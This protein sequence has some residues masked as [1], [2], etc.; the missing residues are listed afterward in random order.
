MNLYLILEMAVAQDPHRVAVTDVDGTSLTT[1]RLNDLAESASKLFRASGAT[2]VGFCGV[3]SC[4]LPVALFGS[5]LAALPFVPLNYRLA[6]EQLREVASRHDIVI[7]AAPKEA[8]R[9]HSLGLTRTIDPSE[10]LEP[11][12]STLTIPDYPPAEAENHALLLYTSGTTSAPKA[13]VL[14]HRHLTS[15]ILGS[16]EFASMAPDDAVIVCVPPYHVA[17]VMNL[18]SNLYSGRRIV[19]LD[20]FDASRWLATVHEQRVTQAMVVPTMLAR[21]VQAYEEAPVDLPSLRSISYGGALMPLKIITRALELFPNVAFT[22]AYGLTETSSTVALLGPQ[23]HRTAIASDDPTVRNR[24]RSVGHPIP[25]IA[26]EIHDEAGVALEPGVVGEIVVRGEQVAGEYLGTST[27]G[28]GWFHTRDR[29]WLDDAGYLFVEGRA[30]DTIIRGGENIAPAEI[31]DVL[32]RH[33]AV[34][35]CAVVGIDDEVWGQRIAA[36]VVLAP[37]ANV[38]PEELIA[39]AKVHL[40]TSKTPEFIAVE[41]SLPYT[42][43]G[44]L[45]RRAVREQLSKEFPVAFE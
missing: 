18:L 22:N 12:S 35:E 41:E 29:G 28:D 14:R 30:D 15:Y 5:S 16:V 20:P 6:D 13:A 11:T 24:L 19:Y 31:E 10:I 25:G 9:L 3:N 40:R 42:D 2:H 32:L 7:V 33:E 17:G 38:Q 39:F 21:I 44:K 4:A 37:G 23:D 36:A 45:L 43:T 27:S 34:V 8:A 1:G 26:I